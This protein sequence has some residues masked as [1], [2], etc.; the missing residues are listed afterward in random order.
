MGA[1]L[2]T[3]LEK[4]ALGLGVASLALAAWLLRYDVAPVGRGGDGGGVAGFVL[5]RWTGDVELLFGLS[6]RPVKPPEPTP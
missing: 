5:D 6:R 2:M 4:I 3:A 1:V